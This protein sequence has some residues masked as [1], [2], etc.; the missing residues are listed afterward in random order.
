MKN[1]TK[2][3][4]FKKQIFLNKYYYRFKLG[5]KKMIMKYYERVH[6]SIYDFDNPILFTE[7]IN[8]RKLD[9][10]PLFTLCADKIKVRDYVEKKVGKKYLI[11]CYF[12]A[13]KLTSK[14][15]DNM[16]KKCVLKTAGGSGTIKIIYNKNKENKKDVISTMRQY[17]KIDFAYIWGEMFYKKIP[18]N[19]I[20]E[21]LLLDKK[22]NIPNDYKFHCFNNNGKFK[23]FLQIEIN[24]FGNHTRNIYD[25]N[26]NLINLTTGLDNYKGKVAKPKNY[27][28][29]IYVAKKLSEDFN[30]VRVDLYNV[31]GK[32]YF[33]ELTFTHNAGFSIFNPGKY[34]ELWG[35]YWK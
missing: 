23:C 14:L 30:Y 35:S 6:G 17:Q 5:K 9:K 34:N 11:P 18:N 3:N 13:K 16:P 24:R 27:D 7:K 20:C 28:E 25:E 19:I 29:M 33:G 32:I 22:G 2:F 31:N 26:F 10:N 8:S 15:Y 12:T 21:K 1:K 4:N